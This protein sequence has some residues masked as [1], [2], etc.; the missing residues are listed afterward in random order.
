M[1]GEFSSRR[2]ES[3]RNIKEEEE[4]APTG[5]PAFPFS[6]RLHPHCRRVYSLYEI[7]KTMDVYHTTW[8][9]E[10]IG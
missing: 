9:E 6:L 2:L 7:R 8:V 5:R 4:E 1:E 10:L 3:S